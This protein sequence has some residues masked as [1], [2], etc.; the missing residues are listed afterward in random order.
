VNQILDLTTYRPN[1]DIEVITM[2][3]TSRRVKREG[4]IDLRFPGL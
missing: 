3:T 2:L 4:G 1:F